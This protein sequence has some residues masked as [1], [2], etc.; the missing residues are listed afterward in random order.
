MCEFI[1][2]TIS[3]PSIFWPALEA[4]ATLIAAIVIIYQLKN[5]REETTAHRFEG[6]RYAM[7]LVSSSEFSKQAANF[8][9]LLDHG[10]PFRF[11]ETMPPVVH[12]ILRTLE[13]VDRLIK[14]GY[15]EEDLF[16]RVEGKRLATL[17]RDIQMIKEGKDTPRFEEQIRLY[18][19]GW[20]LLH[21]AK[22]WEDNLQSN[23]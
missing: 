2:E 10:D 16:F 15:L 3:D 12:W 17:A 18:P 5:L 23:A 19:N 21:R 4:I 7:Q 20:D 14:D 8:H 11:H 13:I 1:R 22:S 9:K 6:F